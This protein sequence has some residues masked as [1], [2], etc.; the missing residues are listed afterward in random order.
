[1]HRLT[2]RLLMGLL[3]VAAALPRPAAGTGIEPRTPGERAICPV[4]GM[5]VAEHRQWLA[6]VVFADG[7][8]AFFDGSRDLFHYLLTPPA[9]GAGPERPEIAAIFVTSYYDLEI[10][11]A[12]SAW[13]VVGSDVL[14]PM[15]P[16]LVPHSTRAEAEEF[17]RD[18][19][20]TRT[21]RF[22]E[23]TPELLRSL[24]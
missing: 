7:S 16:E 3:V 10:L 21:L 13:Y 1:M 24:R 2:L 17:Q 5:F 12:K 19:G 4:C 20:G 8:A 22:E 15:G 14:G 11:P 18:H 6:Q 23:V 9:P